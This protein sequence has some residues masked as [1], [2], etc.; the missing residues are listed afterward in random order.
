MVGLIMN[1]ISG[2]NHSCER[3]E[4]A[5]MVF[6]EYTIISPNTPL[7]ECIPKQTLYSLIFNYFTDLIFG[8]LINH[9]HSNDGVVLFMCMDPKFPTSHESF[10][11]LFINL[12]ITL[13]PDYPNYVH[14]I[15]ALNF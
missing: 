14:N 13:H 6:R 8:V 15:R 5:F 12:Q 7:E 10:P 9:H 3:R 4:H 1:L 11:P 2:T